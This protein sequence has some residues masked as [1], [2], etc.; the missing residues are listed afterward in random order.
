MHH[1]ASRYSL[2]QC[3]GVRSTATGAHAGTEIGV[4][5][6]HAYYRVGVDPGTTVSMP[7]WVVVVLGSALCSMLSQLARSTRSPGGC[8]NSLAC[9]RIERSFMARNEALFVVPVFL[10]A[11]GVA[12][13]L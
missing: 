9:R 5:V 12:T 11:D 6:A 7:R 3:L 2:V 1:S 8:A 13:S 10:L 4:L